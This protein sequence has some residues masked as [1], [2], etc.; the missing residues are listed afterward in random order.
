MAYP[1]LIENVINQ[2]TKLP[3]IGRRSAERIAFWLLKANREEA[4][5]FAASIHKLK[6]GMGFCTACNNFSE[7]ALCAVCSN[8]ARDKQSICVVEYPKDVIAI[9]NTGA[10]KGLYHVLLGAISPS[11]GRGP[12]DLK[13]DKLIERIKRNHIKEVIVATDPDTEG[14]MTAIHIQRE[15]KPTGVKVSRIGLGLPVGSLLEYADLSTLTMSMAAR[16]EM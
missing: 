11:E 2:L 10:Y 14:E 16:R 8:P 1:R 5:A 13:I 4:D 7:S 9:E 15:L 6:A 3:G 12:D